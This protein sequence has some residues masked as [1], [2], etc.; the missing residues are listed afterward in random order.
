MFDPGSSNTA[1]T[2]DQLLEPS[3]T[4]PNHNPVLELALFQ[5]IGCI[6]KALSLVTVTER[7]RRGQRSLT[8]VIHIISQEWRLWLSKGGGFRNSPRT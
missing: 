5:D 3:Y 7:R 1:L 6:A 2:P 8:N 4:G